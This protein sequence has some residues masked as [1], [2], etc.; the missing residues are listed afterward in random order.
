MN[1]QRDLRIIIIRQKNPPVGAHTVPHVLSWVQVRPMLVHMYKYV[2][3]KGSAAMLAIKRSAGVAPEVN[4]KVTSHQWLRYI[5]GH[6]GYATHS[7]VSVSVKKI[8]GAAARQCYSQSTI[9]LTVSFQRQ[10]SVMRARFEVHKK[11]ITNMH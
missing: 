8:K 2:D 11:P 10:S 3:H 6:N 9:T 7:E 4:L 1:L 5:D